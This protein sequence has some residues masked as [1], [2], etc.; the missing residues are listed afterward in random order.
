MQ[1]YSVINTKKAP[2]PIGPYVQAIS[3]QNIV[4]VSG[5]IGICPDTGKIPNN[6]YYQT[7]QTLKNIKNI[8][9]Q[10][11]LQIKNIIKT[12]IFITD[13][14]DLPVINTSYENFFYQHSLL[15]ITLHLPA[16]S[17]VEVSKLPK[18]TKIEIEAIAIRF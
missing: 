2:H 4:F 5:Q 1:H 18:N 7:Q 11:N 12:T 16:R 3:I 9:E 14:N 15:Y 10:S 6:I 13:I 8:I 17:C